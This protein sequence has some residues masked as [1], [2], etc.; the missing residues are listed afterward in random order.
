MDAPTTNKNVREFRELKVCM[1]SERNRR[2]LALFVH[3]E[4]ETTVSTGPLRLLWRL[5]EF[6]GVVLPYLMLHDVL[7]TF[8]TREK[9]RQMITQYSTE[10]N[11]MLRDLDVTVIITV[12]KD[13]GIALCEVRRDSS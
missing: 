3:G 4:R 12:A 8:R 1:S 5:I 11:A 6:P 9:A 10:L 13:Y 2:K 7:R